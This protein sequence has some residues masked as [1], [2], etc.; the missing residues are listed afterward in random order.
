MAIPFNANF[1]SIESCPIGNR[2]NSQI[3]QKKHPD[4]QI[5]ADVKANINIQ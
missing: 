3:L 4:D 1:Y 2:V 5:K